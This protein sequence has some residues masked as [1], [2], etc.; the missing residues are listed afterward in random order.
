MSFIKNNYY[1]KYSTSS[2][3]NCGNKGHHVKDCLE[4]KISLGIILYKKIASEFHYLLICRRN[5]IGIVEFLRGRYVHSDIEYIKKLFNVMT[6]GELDLLINKDFD[7]LW[8]YI[9]MDKKFNKTSTKIQKDYNIAEQ[10]FNKIKEGYNIGDEF[11]DI[12]TLVKNSNSEYTEQEW[13][14]PK[15]RRNY[16]ENDL[17]AALREFNE[18]TDISEIDIRLISNTKTFIEEY[19]SYDNINYKN[20]YY[21]AEYIGNKNI[22]INP[23]KK[24]QYTEISNI[25][26]YNMDASCNKFRNYNEEKKQ[27]LQKVE[28][29]LNMKHCG[30][31][32]NYA[33][34]FN[35]YD[36][37]NNYPNSI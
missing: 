36:R 24:E 10:K 19:K 3:I 4:H 22:E 26:F 1:K 31:R 18:E 5:T 20:I 25:G 30:N 8:E 9:W 12:K 2:C 11:I 16:N 6:I 7:Y 34:L 23:L 15:G 13:G 32:N 14:F 37:N 29:F 21:V 35:R 33:M 17:T 27:I 28:S